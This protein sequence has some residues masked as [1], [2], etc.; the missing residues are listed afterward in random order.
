MQKKQYKILYFQPEFGNI[1]IQF[2]GLPCYNYYAPYKNGA[3]L[4]GQDLDDAIQ[5]LYPYTQEE[6]QA[7]AATLTGG[8]AIAA[9]VEI[10]PTP[11]PPDLGD[12]V[13]IV[14]EPPEQK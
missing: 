10:Q 1:G 12:I 9:M 7:I 14:V 13:G 11:E 5:L 8:E 4:E 2:E 3:Y 6:R